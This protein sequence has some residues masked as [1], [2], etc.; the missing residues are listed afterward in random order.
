MIDPTL[1]LGIATFLAW[2]GLELWF[3]AHGQTT[4]SGRVQGLFRTWPTL[5]MLSGLVV[6]L[7]LAHFF[8]P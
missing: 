5:G 7:L 6:G 4:I 3:V 2:A 8:F 1:A